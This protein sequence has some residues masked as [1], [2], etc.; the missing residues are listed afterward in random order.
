MRSA[1]WILVLV[2]ALAAPGFGVPA[3]LRIGLLHSVSGPLAASE[4]ALREAALLAV[5]ELNASG[6][7]RGRRIEIVA[8]DGASRPEAFAREAERLL[9]AE[10]V[11]ALFGCRFSDCRKAVLPVLERRKRLLFYPVHYEGLESSPWVVYTG[12]APNQQLIPG[13]DWCVRHLGPRLYL[14][15]TES[16]F[17]RT[18]S[19]LIRMR[20]PEL[21]GRIVAE[22]YR[23]LGDRDFREIARE[24]RRRKP[25]AVLSTVTSSDTPALFAA[26][27]AEGVGPASVP[28]MS[29][30]VAEDALRRMKVVPQGHYATWNYFQSVETPANRRFVQAFRARFGADRVTDDPIEAAYFQVRA[31]AQAV[32]RAGTDRPEEVRK[33]LRGMILEAPEGLVRIDPRNQHTWKVARV[34]R[35]RADRQFDIVWSSDVPL[36]PEPYPFR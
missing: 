9:A 35:I 26:L 33:A 23:P 1:A 28:V 10:G 17:S 36:R 32:E 5:E 22:V 21:G 3:P 7:I 14:L 12:A 20:A 27:A 31:Y 30:N 8:G 11:N 2:A 18:A 34:G 16:A 29:F 19:R 15:G 25:D 4:R 6:G 13:V 24:L